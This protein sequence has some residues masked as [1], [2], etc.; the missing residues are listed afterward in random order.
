[1]RLLIALAGGFTA[2]LLTGLMLGVAP[3]FQ[4]GRP[5]TRSRRMH[6][7]LGQVGSPLTPGQFLAASAGVGIAT[8]VALRLLVGGWVISFFPAI[9][10]SGYLAWSYEQ[11]RRTRLKETREAWPDALRQILSYVR[12][13][14]TIP[15]AVAAIAEQGPPALR[16]S[17]EGWDRRSQLL[18]FVPALETVRGQLADPTADRVIEVLIIAHEWGGDLVLEVLEALAR[19][20]D[21]DL[22]TERAIRAAGTTQRVEVWV[23]GIAPWLLLIY[24]TSS[25]AAYRDFYGTGI[26]RFVILAAGVWWALGL[27]VLRLVKKAPVEKRVLG[28]AA[29]VDA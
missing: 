5:S 18:G 16:S 10:C 22:R 2:F 20:I 6:V 1:M 25:Q 26:G 29:E 13:G 8:W 12:S 27:L 21:E 28:A 9:A 11:R 7:W 24:L 4:T 14:A 3:D 23:V 15:V 17:F 19:E